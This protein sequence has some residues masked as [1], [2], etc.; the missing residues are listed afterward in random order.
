MQQSYSRH[1]FGHA[2]KLLATPM[3]S[4]CRGGSKTSTSSCWTLLSNQAYIER[5]GLEATPVNHVLGHQTDGSQLIHEK[6]T[7][8]VALMRGGEP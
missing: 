7:T 6:Q 8:I 2:A 4:N 3:R 5:N 1:Q